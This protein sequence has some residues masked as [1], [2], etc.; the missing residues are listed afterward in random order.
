MQ[1]GRPDEFFT[2][3]QIN[4]LAGL[5]AK[6]R[7]CRDGGKSLSEVEELELR[8]LVDAELEGVAA[9]CEGRLESKNG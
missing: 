3:Q 8:A 4:R 2:A 5:M 1:I 6:W 7:S 9:R